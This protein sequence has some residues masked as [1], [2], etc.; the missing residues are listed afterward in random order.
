VRLAIELQHSQQVG[1]NLRGMKAAG[2][3]IDDGHGSL[4]REALDLVVPTHARHD[5]IDHR[6]DD[7]RRVEQALVDAQL[8]V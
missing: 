3:C 6:A 8:D 5:T 1:K 2:E 7:A 4:V